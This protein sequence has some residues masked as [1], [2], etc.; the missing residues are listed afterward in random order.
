LSRWVSQAWLWQRRLKMRDMVMIM[1]V[2]WIPASFVMFTSNTSGASRPELQSQVLEQ[3]K[4]ELSREA[5][6][7]AQAQVA[8]AASTSLRARRDTERLA[9]TSGGV[10][11]QGASQAPD[12]W[13]V[14]PLFDTRRRAVTSDDL[15]LVQHEAST[16]KDVCNDL[17]AKNTDLL[18]TCACSGM[19]RGAGA[20]AADVAGAVAAAAG[21]G[22]GA[23]VVVACCCC[24][25]CCWCC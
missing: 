24:C 2:I 21:G 7:A 4:G 16:W 12:G 18:E 8:A 11:A 17:L 25:C 20:G 19:L 9:P 15:D 6:R 22:G 13:P 3:L 14:K 23:A 1:L 10:A 5:A